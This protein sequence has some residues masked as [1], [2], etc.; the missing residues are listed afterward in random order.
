[1]KRILVI[2]GSILLSVLAIRCAKS[3]QPKDLSIGKIDIPSFR[4]GE[5]TAHFEVTNNSD[6]MKYITVETEMSFEG[7]Y[8]HPTRTV[9]TYFPVLPG[10][11]E[12][13]EPTIEIP[14]NYGKATLAIRLYDVVDT[15]DEL[16][17]S[18][19]VFEQ[20]FNIRFHIPDEMYEYYR[21]VVL[22]PPMVENSPYW[23]NE[24][25][26]VLLLMLKDSLSVGEIADMAKAD[27]SF[28]EDVC[29]QMTRLG[30]LEHTPEG[31]FHPAIPVFSTEQ[32]DET[33]ALVEET[34]DD[35]AAI[36]EGN[37]DDYQQVLDSLVRAGAVSPDTFDFLNFG[38]ILYHPYPTIGGLLLWYDMGQAFITGSDPLAIF[39]NTDPCHALIGDYMYAVHGGQNYVGHQYYDLMI[40]PVELKILFGD[41][42]PV[43]DCP[44]D[45]SRIRQL[46]FRQDYKPDS[47]Y[48][49]E[50]YI[51][52][53][54][55]IAPALRALA[56][57]GRAN[58]E[59]IR[60]RLVAISKKYGF[61][62]VSV[63]QRYWFWN[64]FATRTLDKLVE[65]GLIEREG[66]GQYFFTVRP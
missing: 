51:V 58:Y 35:L 22:M 26:R 54:A 53:K 39:Q 47:A 31:N 49:P 4:W 62:E 65:Q 11:T 16:M 55:I 27:T 43:M 56:E 48:S 30:F 17:A 50:P 18:Q 29:K 44:E 63:G 10:K 3:Q 28:V 40:H 36:I 25:S 37:M 8:L 19:Q 6:W 1:L 57:G 64:Q 14:G 21:E 46:R 34:S 32:A 2:L 9:H 66:K 12:L 7:I 52:S 15:L 42:I 45:L 5:Q 38:T 13:L 20:F 41:T 59:T 33:R 60:D 23:D 61:P 24:F